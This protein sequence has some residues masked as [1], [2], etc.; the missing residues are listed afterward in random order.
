MVVSPSFDFVFSVLV[1][2]LGTKSISEM[3]YFVSSGMYNLNQLPVSSCLHTNVAREN[4]Y[5]VRYRGRCE[6]MRFLMKC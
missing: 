1:K 4:V 6:Q 3:T 5:V 2:R